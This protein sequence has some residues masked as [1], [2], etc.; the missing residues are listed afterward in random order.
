VTGSGNG[1]VNF[2]VAAN[3]NSIART[4]TLTVGG[5]SFTVTQGGQS[6]SYSVSPT[7]QSFNASG[8]TGNVNMTAAQGCNWTAAR[9][10]NFIPINSGAS[11]SANGSVALTI[12]ANTS[13]TP[14]M[15]TLTVAGQTFTVTQAAATTVNRSMRVGT[16]S[17]SIGDTVAVPIELV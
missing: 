2:T 17:G 1:T 8:G 16:A 10:S 12:A 4:G 7:N 14:R 13:T 3:N 9:N 15:G 11:G 6:C 5:Q